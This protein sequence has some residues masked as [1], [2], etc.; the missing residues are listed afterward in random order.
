MQDMLDA[1]TPEG[2]VQ[3]DSTEPEFVKEEGSLNFSRRK[4][5][6]DATAIYLDHDTHGPPEHYC[7]AKEMQ[8]NYRTKVESSLVNH[9]AYYYFPGNQY[10][11]SGIR[12]TMKTLFIHTGMVERSMRDD[13]TKRVLIHSK[14]DKNRRLMSA[15]MY[16]NKI[17]QYYILNPNWDTYGA[18]VISRASIAKA[19]E[20]VDHIYEIGLRVNH[21]SPTRQSGIAM[22]VDKG[23][24]R[25]KFR[26]HDHLGAT[27]SMIEDNSV[28]N[29]GKLNAK[30]EKTC[31]SWLTEEKQA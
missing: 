4:E 22:E 27:F 6:R 16:K 17:L 15:E 11:D 30:N 8:W 14:I 23:G 28:I 25:V 21:V 10:L 5:Y 12:E 13:P 3:F 19:C 31:L 1:H 7:L 2:E 26:F 18:E 20:Y 29:K 9:G 24:R